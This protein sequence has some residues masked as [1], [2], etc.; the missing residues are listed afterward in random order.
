MTQKYVYEFGKRWL[1]QVPRRDIK[2]LM[3]RVHVATAAEEIEADIR[4]RCGN[5]KPESVEAGFTAIVVK[6]SVAYAFECHKRNR[7]L[8]ARVMGGNV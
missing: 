6:Q 8:Y 3:S 5:G 1:P 4:R 7:D 2:W